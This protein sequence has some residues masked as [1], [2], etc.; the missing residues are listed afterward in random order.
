MCNC[1]CGGNGRAQVFGMY[2][3]ARTA[4]SPFCHVLT[5]HKTS[6]YHNTLLYYTVQLLFHHHDHIEQDEAEFKTR[7][8]SVDTC[9]SC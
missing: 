6:G 1:K 9:I 4:S 7:H 3:N 2:V 8:I 5:A